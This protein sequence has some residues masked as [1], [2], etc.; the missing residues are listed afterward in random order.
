VCV[1]VYVKCQKAST[2]GATVIESITMHNR[3]KSRPLLKL[4]KKY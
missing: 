4:A 2:V 3:W 1:C